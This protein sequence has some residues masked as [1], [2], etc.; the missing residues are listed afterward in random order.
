MNHTGTEETDLA[1]PSSLCL[2]SVSGAGV[3]QGSQTGHTSPRAENALTLEDI[4]PRPT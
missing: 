1:R 3:L 4:W 2:F